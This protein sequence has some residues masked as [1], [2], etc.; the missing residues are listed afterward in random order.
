[1]IQ[2]TDWLR[3]DYQ[4]GALVG[5]AV[6]ALV[7]WLGDLYGLPPAVLLF[8]AGANLLY[9]A[10]SFTL[11]RLRPLPGS[12]PIGALVAANLLW[13]GVCAGMAI[14]FSGYASPL[15]MAHLVAEGL[16]VGGLA[17]VEWTQR[18]RLRATEFAQD[19]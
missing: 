17:G 8:T 9:A 2:T 19:A 14:S 16:F 13:A 10:F 4:A 18:E 3:V 6:L 11:T 1:M 15:G 5:L 12:G 7:G